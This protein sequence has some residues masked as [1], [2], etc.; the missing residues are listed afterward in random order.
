MIL[1]S[2]GGSGAGLSMSQKTQTTAISNNTT[3]GTAGGQ[4]HHLQLLIEKMQNLPANA[5]WAD[6]QA[7]LSG[8]ITRLVTTQT[9][10]KYLQNSQL[11]KSNP[12]LIEFL[13]SEIGD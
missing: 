4:E 10:S 5:S 1:N 11:T 2:Y 8:N 6:K 9:G 13:L 12:V 3:E 7:I